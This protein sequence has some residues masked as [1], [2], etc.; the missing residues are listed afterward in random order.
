M[1]QALRIAAPSLVG[2]LFLLGW[3]WLVQ[4]KGIPSY[5]LPGPWLI[6]QT[7]V[8]DWTSLLPSLVITAQITFA[9]LFVAATLGLA[10]A[11]AA[12][13]PGRHLILLA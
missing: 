3:E 2:A 1:N 12:A 4:A 6:A 5:V 7:L 11:I 10:L 8:R 13:E 9:A